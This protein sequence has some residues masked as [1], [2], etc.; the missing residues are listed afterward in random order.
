MPGVWPSV[1]RGFHGEPCA[2]H[3][4]AQERHHVGGRPGIPERV[5]Q[6]PV[7]LRLD[8]E[9]DE[10]ARIFSA[11]AQGGR[12]VSGAGTAHAASMQRAEPNLNLLEPV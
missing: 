10:L 8:P 12:T 1:V 9:C 3:H 6:N 4:V 11:R 7:I 5:A 2:G